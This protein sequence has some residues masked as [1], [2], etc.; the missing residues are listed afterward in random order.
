M[1]PITW[2]SATERF[3]N[4]NECYI[5]RVKVGYVF[6]PSRSRND[7]PFYRAQIDLPG[8]TMKE[9]TTDHPTEAAAMARLEAAIGTWFR[10]LEIE[11]A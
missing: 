8:I 3:S 7:A 6:M 5:G 2:K 9:G 4:A 1:Q 10:W 11:A